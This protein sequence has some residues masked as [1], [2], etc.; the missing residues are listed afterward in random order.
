MLR[1]TLL[2]FRHTTDQF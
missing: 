1:D 2:Q